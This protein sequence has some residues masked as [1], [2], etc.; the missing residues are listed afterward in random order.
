MF[1]SARDL[2]PNW[3]HERSAALRAKIKRRSCVR[4]MGRFPVRSAPH[5]PR[6]IRSATGLLVKTER[7]LEVV[8]AQERL[9][10]RQKTSR[11]S[12]NAKQRSTSVRMG[13]DSIRAPERSRT[14]RPPFIPAAS[15][16]AIICSTVAKLVGNIRPTQRRTSLRHAEPNHLT[17]IADPDQSAILR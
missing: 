5:V 11:P 15:S 6:T 9:F 10:A 12:M 7:Q 1:S 4:F 8:H 16:I 14:E 2:D 13:I 3:R 17:F